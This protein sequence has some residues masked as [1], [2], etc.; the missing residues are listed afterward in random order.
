MAALLIPAHNGETRSCSAEGLIGKRSLKTERSVWAVG[1][2][3]RDGCLTRPGSDGQLLTGAGPVWVGVSMVT[4]PPEK[5]GLLFCFTF[6]CD[7]IREG[8]ESQSNN[9]CWRSYMNH[10]AL[11][12]DYDV[13]VAV[14]QNTWRGVG[15][16]GGGGGQGQAWNFKDMLRSCCCQA[17]SVQQ[18][19]LKF[20]SDCAARARFCAAVHERS[21]TETISRAI[22]SCTAAPWA[23]QRPMRVHLALA[24]LATLQ[25]I[26]VKRF[27]VWF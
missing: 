2:V 3:A 6:T 21:M 9:Y 5:G 27:W 19:R 22:Q 13:H 8:N 25:G 26:W 24:P 17:T 14:I 16:G 4:S 10:Q 12:M 7:S 23:V 1:D 15:E 11:Y 20:Y 18:Q